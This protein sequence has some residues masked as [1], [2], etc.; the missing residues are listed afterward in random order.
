MQL[1][2]AVLKG[3]P[4]PSPELPLPS[5]QNREEGFSVVYKVPRLQYLVIEAP[6]LEEAS[7]RP[8][9]HAWPGSRLW[10][11]TRPQETHRC[12]L[13]GPGSLANAVPRLDSEGRN[14]PA[15]PA[16]LQALCG[17][18]RWKSPETLPLS[19]APRG[20]GGGRPGS[21]SVQVE[22]GDP[23]PRAWGGPGCP[24]TR[25]QGDP[26]RR[27]PRPSACLEG[28]TRPGRSCPGRPQTPCAPRPAPSGGARAPLPGLGL[29]SPPLLSSCCVCLQ[30]PLDSHA[31]LTPQ[32]CPTALQK[33]DGFCLPGKKRHPAREGGREG[34]PCALAPPA[35]PP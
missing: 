8:G 6:A 11:R 22:S 1:E 30:P 18:R 26:G 33:P 15:P 27:R 7:L 19:P 32:R 10:V 24:G 31:G 29:A 12:G 20:A 25:P 34:G 3:H 13:E 28:G 21:R 2:G 17:H 16:P 5:L 23:S 4:G 14:L 9:G 35:P